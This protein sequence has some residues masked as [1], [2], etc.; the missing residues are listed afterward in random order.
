[1]QL[2]RSRLLRLVLG[3]VLSLPLLAATGAPAERPVT[4]DELERAIFRAFDAGDHARASTLIE[5]YLERWPNQPAMLYN[6]ACAYAQSGRVDEA[7]SALYRAVEAGFRDLS[8]LRRDPDLEPIRH[9]EIYKAILKAEQRVA[10]E[11]AEALVRAWRDRFGDEN[12]R[13]EIDEKHR[14]AFA[15]AL[16]ETSHREMRE[17]LERQ[18]DVLIHLLFEEPPDYYVLIAV[19]TPEDARELFEGEANIGGRYE[20][21]EH[22]LVSRDTGGSL[23]HEFVHAMH[24]GHMER[25]GI[26]RPHPLWIQEGLATLFEDYR[27]KED[28]SVTF[29]PND[30]HG[31]IQRRLKHA[32]VMPWRKFFDLSADR[33]MSNAGWT[34][35]MTRSIFEFLAEQEKLGAWY[36]AYV[37]SYSEDASGASAFEQVFAEPLETIEQQ[38]R[39]WLRDR[40]AVDRRIDVG[41]AALGVLSRP[42]SATDGVV[43]DEVLPGSSAAAGGL[44]RGDVI[45][46]I[47]GRPT[48]SFSELRGLI[49]GKAIG[50]RIE[51]RLRRNGDYASTTLVLRPLPRQRIR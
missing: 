29:L 19:P 39:R 30:R 21:A 3:V 41:D 26:R 17:M 40:P 6:L 32:T 24:Y 13:F 8:H 14:L 12:Y 2:S 7:T 45:V 37:S 47:D 25:L 48:R 16:D 50:D 36:R 15:T 27:I 34:Y 51:V 10:G 38:W 9:T 22:R 42:N 11:R 31:V 28:G 18:A 44:R 1:M 35:P 23:R 20:H 49:A 4:P 5:A 46:A 33:F 43:I